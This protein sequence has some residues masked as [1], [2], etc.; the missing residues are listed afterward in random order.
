MKE[1]KLLPRSFFNPKGPAFAALFIFTPLA[2]LWALTIP[3]RSDG[4]V[5]DYAQ[6]LSPAAKSSI[7][8]KLSRFETET[9]NQVVVVT[10]PSLEGE[11]LEDFSIRLAEAWRVGQKEKDNGVILFI[12]KK[13]RAVRIEVGYGLESVLTDAI[14]KDIIENRIV[15]HFR[16]GRY[17]EGVEKA[18]EAIFA[19]TRKEY[20]PILKST[21]KGSWWSEEFIGTLFAA[22]FI[23][24]T[25]LPTAL[26][27]V[28]FF[29]GFATLFVSLG[30]QWYFLTACAFLLGILP[31]PLHYLFHAMNRLGSGTVIGSRRGGGSHGSSWGSGGGWSSGGFSGGG[32]SFGGGGASGRW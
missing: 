6:L 32:G 30:L 22:W 23:L 24:P 21:P 13:E 27:R 2:C 12:T 26:L 14:S 18:V 20:K 10:F 7:E 29:L 9:S 17:D 5:S 1:P 3:E 31:L 19:A 15:P 28:L 8:S 4:Y 11:S 25:L 16:E